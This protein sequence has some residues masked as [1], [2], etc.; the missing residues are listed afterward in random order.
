[1][2][3]TSRFHLWTKAGILTVSAL[4]LAACDDGFELP[5]GQTASASAPEVDPAPV[6]QETGLEVEAPEVFFAEETALWDGRPSLGGVWIAHPDVTDPE[7][8]LMTN[9]QSGDSVVGALF[10]RERDLPGPALM[11]S[12]DA[13]ASLNVI[14]GEPTE[15]VVVAL[16]R[17]EIPE[18]LNIPAAPPE[19][20]VEDVAAQGGEDTA[21]PESIAATSLDTEAVET[22]AVAE[23]AISELEEPREID[24]AAV[25]ADAIAV[26]ATAAPAPVA[27]LNAAD[28][29]ADAAAVPAALSTTT[30]DAPSAA[31]PAPSPTPRP[32]TA[33]TDVAV[34]DPTP[35]PSPVETLER[36]YIQVGIYSAAANADV[37]ADDL[38]GS[39]VIPRV[40]DQSNEDRAL[41]RVIVG[42]ARNAAERDVL[43]ETVQGLG[44]EDAYFVTN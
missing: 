9:A 15:L 31:A 25:A 13:A 43:L 19:A 14:A 12:S 20:V 36:P 42:P 28:I 34:V 17:E 35:A 32:E 21:L 40:L 6:A 16:R 4:A 18:D 37:A 5:F 10:R 24:V 41:W 7:R 29:A 26:S 22:T 30:L 11:L 44:Y 38:R 23:A 39:G 8:V 2:K 27:T 1:M 33:N 3:K